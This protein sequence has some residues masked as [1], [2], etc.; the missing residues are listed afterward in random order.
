MVIW[1]SHLIAGWIQKRPAGADHVCSSGSYSCLGER[2]LADDGQ[3]IASHDSIKHERNALM[4]S[5]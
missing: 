3:M 2:K 4:I 1:R 5:W